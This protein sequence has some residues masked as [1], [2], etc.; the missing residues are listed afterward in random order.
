MFDTTARDYADY[1]RREAALPHLA[2]RYREQWE[3]TV[4][5]ERLERQTAVERARLGISPKPAILLP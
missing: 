2:A 4:A 5:L 1:R 3:Q